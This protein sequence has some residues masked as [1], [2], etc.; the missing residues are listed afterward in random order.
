MMTEA[1]L[2]RELVSIKGVEVSVLD[3][4]ELRGKNLFEAERYAQE[5]G[6]V[7]LS[8]KDINTVAKAVKSETP[9][10]EFVRHAA[11]NGLDKELAKKAYENLHTDIHKKYWVEGSEIL[12]WSASDFHPRI[13]DG[14][15]RKQLK[16]F[17]ITDY[18]ITDDDKI[19]ISGRAKPK[20]VNWPEQNGVITPE[21]AELLNAP[22]NT[23]V[24]TNSDV[25][26]QEGLRALDWDFG[27]RER[28]DLYS[29]WRPWHR[30]SDIGSLLGKSKS[31]N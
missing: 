15:E 31:K 8:S 20:A 16:S 26:Y 12:M 9:T 10:S 2:G 29:D 27:G 6:L 30:N 1:Y 28:P 18:K 7:R 4:V 24:Y 14:E 25:N 17:L 19:D 5:N 11:K 21:I 13:I 22:S 3:G 23:F